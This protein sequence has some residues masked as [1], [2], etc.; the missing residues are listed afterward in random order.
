MQ[1]IFKM[2]V[3]KQSNIYSL[4]FL[5]CYVKTILPLWEVVWT[6]NSQSQSCGNKILGFD[7][8]KFLKIKE[9]ILILN[10][11]KAKECSYIALKR[12]SS[13]CSMW[14]TTLCWI[15]C[16]SLFME[17]D[18]HHAVLYSTAMSCIDSK[19]EHWTWQAHSFLIRR[20]IYPFYFLQKHLI[21][22]SITL[23]TFIL[24][25]WCARVVSYCQL[26][27]YLNTIT[28]WTTGLFLFYNFHFI[29]S[30]YA[31]NT[32]MCVL[33]FVNSIKW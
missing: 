23:N 7:S 15:G 27:S 5:T 17:L 21:K 18:I 1:Y 22:M 10:I 13:S 31:A 11:K 19:T 4:W 30:L 12:Q 16:S 8:K 26:L 6:A 32:S 24:L 33:C 14:Y 20:K 25:S 2:A 29:R 28:F 3:T 9:K